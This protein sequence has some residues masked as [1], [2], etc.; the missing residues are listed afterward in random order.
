MEPISIALA[1]AQFV[2]GLTRMLMGDKAADV[3]DKVVQV[4]NTVTG[5]D[6]PSEA[7]Q[8]IKQDPALQLQ[9]QKEVNQ[10]IIAEMESDLKRLESINA[11]MRVEAQSNDVVVR[12]WR[13]YFGYAVAISW[14]IQMMALSYIIIFRPEQS[15]TVISALS[16]LSVMWSVALSVLGVYV[17]KRSEDKAVAAGREL[18]IGIFG[19]VAQRIA[20]SK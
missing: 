12:R 10:L 18:P 1:L 5:R 16:E 20:G 11:T 3:A 6:N 9:L 13:P 14:F 8:Q 19:A 7:L 2:P 17:N 4:A 15:A